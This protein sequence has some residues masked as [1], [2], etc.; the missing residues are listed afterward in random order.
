MITILVV[1]EQ[2]VSGDIHQ[3]IGSGFLSAWITILIFLFDAKDNH[4]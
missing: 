1:I 2:A 3:R 4:F